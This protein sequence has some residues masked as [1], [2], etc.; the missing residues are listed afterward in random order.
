M[1]FVY[2]TPATEAEV[3]T[4]LSHRIKRDLASGG[5]FLP[6]LKFSRPYPNV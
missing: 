3:K 6:H 2:T 4:R 5:V 1:N